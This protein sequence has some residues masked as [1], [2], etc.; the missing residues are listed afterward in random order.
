M[1]MIS[2]GVNADLEVSLHDAASRRLHEPE[3][4]QSYL[5][6]ANVVRILYYLDQ[7]SLAAREARG[8]KPQ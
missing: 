4:Q 6:L 8:G 5:L 7:T 1:K 3:S 2:R